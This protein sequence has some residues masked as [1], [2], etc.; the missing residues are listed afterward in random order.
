LDDRFNLLTH[1]L[2]NTPARHQT[3]RATI[4]WS[5]DLLSEKE[6][7]V[8][9][10]LGVFVGGWTLGAAEAVCSGKGMPPVELLDLLSRLVD[11]SLVTVDTLDDG[12]RYRRLEPSGS[13]RA[14]DL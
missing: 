6:R 10:R 7:L 3:L 14:S 8:F 4:E 12:N 2:R 13:M 9:K 1:G 5:Y 11:K